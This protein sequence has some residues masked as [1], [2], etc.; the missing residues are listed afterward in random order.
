[1]LI[2]ELG[3]YL[4]IFPIEAIGKYLLNPSSSLDFLGD[5]GT[6]SRTID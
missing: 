4:K 5:A 3:S 2:I 1:M 6:F